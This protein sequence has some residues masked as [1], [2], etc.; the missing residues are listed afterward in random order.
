MNFES[1]F[2][3][4]IK[5]DKAVR[6]S[7]KI[8]IA[9]LISHWPT[10]FTHLNKR[11]GISIIPGKEEEAKEILKSYYF[12]S[13]DKSETNNKSVVIAKLKDKL[14]QD[15]LNDVNL[16][17]DAK[18]TEIRKIRPDLDLT[19]K[20]IKQYI[21][22]NKTLAPTP[23]SSS[24]SGNT[25]SKINIYHPEVQTILND[26]NLSRSEKINQITTKYPSLTSSQINNFLTKKGIK[27]VNKFD[28]IKTDLIGMEMVNNK[29]IIGLM[30]RY[31]QFTKQQLINF[32]NRT[33]H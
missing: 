2:E 4:F 29:N 18:I 8:T 28:V 3:L 23:M 6:K 12:P 31:P 7:F 22:R 5:N 17:I 15:I 32:V 30:E 19:D 25:E 14:I 33:T 1:D 9:N 11:S 13:A 21:Y 27:T 16:T 26:S 10:V 24:S 20:Q